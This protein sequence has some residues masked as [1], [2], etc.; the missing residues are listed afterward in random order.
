MCHYYTVELRHSPRKRKWFTEV[1]N[2]RILLNLELVAMHGVLGMWTVSDRVNF[3]DNH[4][5]CKRHQ[6]DMVYCQKPQRYT[7]N[8]HSDKSRIN[9]DRS[10]RIDCIETTEVFVERSSCNIRSC[11]CWLLLLVF[12]GAFLVLY[13]NIAVP[14]AIQS[15]HPAP[16]LMVVMIDSS[17][18]RT[19]DYSVFDHDE[20]YFRSYLDF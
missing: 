7:D 8:S 2:G 4:T 10:S 9:C 12:L 11:C 15:Q 18:Y 20:E 13:M 3:I 1:L 17:E 6:Y 14:D 16:E 19:S 5:Y